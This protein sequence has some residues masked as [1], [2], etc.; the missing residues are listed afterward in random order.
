[1][2]CRKFITKILVACILFLS[3]TV[4]AKLDKPSPTTEFEKMDFFPVYPTFSWQ[5]IAKAEFYQVQ[6]VQIFD[7][8]EKIVRELKN[9]EGID[10]VTDFQPFTE[11]GKYFWQVRAVNE[12]NIP[13][14]DW[15]EK[16]FFEVTAP[17]KFAVLGDSISHGGASFIPAGQLSC[18]WQTFCKIPVKNIARSGDTTAMMIKRFDADVLPFKPEVLIIFGGT[19]D[20]RE[21]ATAKQVIKNLKTLQK[22][23][24]ENE[25][26]PVFVTLTPMNEK[27]IRSRTGIFL[28]DKNWRKEREKVNAWILKNKFAVDVSKNLCDDDGELKKN[29]TPDGLHPDVRGKKIIGEEIEKFL[30]ANFAEE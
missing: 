27:I 24:V 1:M 14:G 28:T 2:N 15:S 4:D 20:I 18:Q 16:S 25:I 26:T 19:N 12:A 9:T 13:L 5:P 3:P 29:L 22:K 8:E 6:V 23:C 7:D 30:I 21:G 11:V 17:V 10:R